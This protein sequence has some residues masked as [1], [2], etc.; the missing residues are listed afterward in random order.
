MKIAI[1]GNIIDTKHIYN[2]TSINKSNHTHTNRIKEPGKQYDYLGYSF[3]IEFFNKKS[4]IINCT[5]DDLFIKKPNYLWND[6]YK[7]DYETKYQLVKNHIEKFRN[8]IIKI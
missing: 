3:E 4:L 7:E 8:S 6:W 1:N 2:I 5:G